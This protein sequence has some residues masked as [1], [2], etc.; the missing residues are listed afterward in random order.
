MQV[1]E[2]KKNPDNWAMAIIYDSKIDKNQQ[3][4]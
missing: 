3:N 4:Q 1:E 2:N